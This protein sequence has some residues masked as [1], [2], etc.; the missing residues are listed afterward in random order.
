[1]LRITLL[2]FTLQLAL[3]Q[4]PSLCNG[5]GTCD[6]LSRCTCQPGYTGWSCASRECP[7]GSA[8]V[9]KASTAS[10]LSVHGVSRVCSG[11][12]L[13][14]STTGA[15]QCQPGSGG[16][17]CE[18]GACVCVL[19][20]RQRALLSLAAALYPALTLSLSLTHT[21]ASVLQPPAQWASPLQQ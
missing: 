3:S 18:Q 17:A 8:Y 4:C 6:S 5:R 15:C 12:G 13:C 16:R 20:C 9:G 21:R 1:M 11:R 7:S 19:H 10:S 14:D 2:C